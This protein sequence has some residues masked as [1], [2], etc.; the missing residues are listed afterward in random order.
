[1]DRI[2]RS[3]RYTLIDGRSGFSIVFAGMKFEE[4]DIV[5]PWLQL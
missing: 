5:P 1:M 2:D 4:E 3:G